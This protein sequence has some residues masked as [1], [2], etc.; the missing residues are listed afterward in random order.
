MPF[1]YIKFSY[2]FQSQEEGYKKSDSFV[3]ELA[4]VI[5]GHHLDRIALLLC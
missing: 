2:I 5:I 1:L 3:D 4:I